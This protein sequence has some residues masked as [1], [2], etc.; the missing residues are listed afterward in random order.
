LSLSS[1]SSA[2]A[3]SPPPKN[4]K[5]YDKN[6]AELEIVKN[7]SQEIFK[8]LLLLLLLLVVVLVI[9]PQILTRRDSCT[10]RLFAAA[11]RGTTREEPIRQGRRM[12]EHSII[13]STT[14]P[15][16]M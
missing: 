16:W 13:N 3:E 14:M 7:I 10:P 8:L 2:F 6:A 15:S 9:P 5:I 4:Q 1:C 12:K 11:S